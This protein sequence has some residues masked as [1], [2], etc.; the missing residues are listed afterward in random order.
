[1]AFLQKK[2]NVF[3]ICESKK[4]D[5]KHKTHWIKIG[6]VP[7]AQA[8]AALAKYISDKTFL[9]LGISPAS[10]ITFSKMCE[11]FR[12]HHSKYSNKKP[13][14]L[15]ID[16]GFL[17]QFEIKFND[18]KFSEVTEKMYTDFFVEREYK[19]KT[20]SLMSSV[21]SQVY[22]FAIEKKYVNENVAL[23][24]KKPKIIP[25]SPRY[26]A[27]EDIELIFSVMRFENT[28]PYRIMYYTGIRPSECL[29]LCPK[30][31]DLKNR[32]LNLMPDQTKTSQ[33]RIIPIPDSAIFIFEKL[34]KGKS[35]NDR[36]IPHKKKLHEPLGK[37]CARASKKYGRPIKVTQYQFRHTYATLALKKSGN[38]RA[39][40]Q[41]L[42]HST[43]AMTTRY[44]TALDEQLKS[45]ANE[46]PE[47]K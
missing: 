36:L 45:I 43:I 27:L 7:P 30:N 26:A 10:K 18:L 37:A 16:F 11:L 17:K 42:G 22:K 31:V 13:Y 38:I 33:G 20:I 9:R 21:L 24:I 34:I 40:Q 41:L 5:G 32:V 12:E 23:K 3:Y 15:K 25:N 1:M 14:T 46:I 8:K 4:I 39:V 29:R 28:I 6:V 35:A 2:K 44:A 47:L 19:P